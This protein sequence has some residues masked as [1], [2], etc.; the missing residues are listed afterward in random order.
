MD[1]RYENPADNSGRFYTVKVWVNGPDN[2]EAHT[3]AI[4]EALDS[5]GINWEFV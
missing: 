1:E 2:D 3:E 4:E 5:T